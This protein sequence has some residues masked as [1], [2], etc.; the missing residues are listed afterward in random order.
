VSEAYDHEL[1]D[2]LSS[3]RKRTMHARRIVFWLSHDV[4]GC[5][6]TEIGQLLGRDHSSS[7]A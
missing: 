4:F 7:V 3:Q 2:I 5:S 6:S 1:D